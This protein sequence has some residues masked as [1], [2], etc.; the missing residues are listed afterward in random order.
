MKQDIEWNVVSISYNPLTLY[1]LIE[2]NV[3]G[4]TEDQYLFSTVY[5]QDIG[6]YKFR[7]ETLSNPQWYKRCN[8]KVDVGEAIGVTQKYKVLLEYVAQDLHTQDF[9]TLTEAD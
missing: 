3:L 8:K 4:K 2:R 1:R 7:Q 5:N 9:S 6:F